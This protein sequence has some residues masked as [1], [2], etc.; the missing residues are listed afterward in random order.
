MTTEYEI[1][2]ASQNEIHIHLLDCDRYFIPKLSDKV[3]IY[4]Y[5]EKIFNAAINF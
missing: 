4:E 2:A 5:S 1:G 3:D